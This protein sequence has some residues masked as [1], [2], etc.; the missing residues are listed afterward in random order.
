VLLTPSGQAKTWCVGRSTLRVSFWWRAREAFTAPGKFFKNSRSH[1]SSKRCTDA[2][3]LRPDYG[4]VCTTHKHRPVVRDSASERERG[5]RSSY[6]DGYK[7]VD[8]GKPLRLSSMTKIKTIR[9]RY[10]AC[11]TEL[12]KVSFAFAQNILIVVVAY[13]SHAAVGPI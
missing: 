12:G 7:T 10:R 3:T 6:R 5:L 11:G 13:Y 1:R 8:N 4:L 9:T 2:R